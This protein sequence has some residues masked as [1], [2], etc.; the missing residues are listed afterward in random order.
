MKSLG[1]ESS[2]FVISCKRAYRL[3]DIEIQSNGTLSRS[4]DSPE[5]RLL[6]GLT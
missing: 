2:P 3:F 4:L 5:E 1:R 6:V